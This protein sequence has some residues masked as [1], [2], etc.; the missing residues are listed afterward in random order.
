MRVTELTNILSM[1]ITA[2]IN[3]YEKKRKKY[4]NNIYDIS[5]YKVCTLYIYTSFNTVVCAR[6]VVTVAWHPRI[7]NSAKSAIMSIM[8]SGRV[9]DVQVD[10]L[11]LHPHGFAVTV[12]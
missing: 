4:G 2:L 5:V 8:S 3:M 12:I 6:C 1:K 7:L 10:V 9:V 11:C